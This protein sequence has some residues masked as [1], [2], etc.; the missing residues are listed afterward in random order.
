M[1]KQVRNYTALLERGPR[2]TVES[3]RSPSRPEG[4]LS[5]QRQA[6]VREYLIDMNAGHAAVRAGYSPANGAAAGAS[7]MKVPA[8]R[9]AIRK[10]VALRSVRVGLTA[11]RVLGE[12]GKIL[13]GDPRAIFDERGGLKKPGDLNDD[14]AMMIAGVKTRRIVEMN[15]DTEEMQNVEIQEIKIVDKLAAMRM[16]MQHLGMLKE[17]LEV[18]HGGPL[19]EQLAAAIARTEGVKAEQAEIEGAE[20]LT[21][22]E[23]QNLLAE[24]GEIVEGE[25]IEDEPEADGLTDEQRRLLY[26]E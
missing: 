25:L 23:L 22:E 8:V 15:P 7:L 4:G 5:P 14:D 6:F 2:Q 16:A 24:E 21:A 26:G 1:A 11:D 13:L 19:A 10:A 3:R 18:N 20:G 12:L 17:T 9:D